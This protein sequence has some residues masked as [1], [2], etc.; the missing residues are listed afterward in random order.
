MLCVVG[1]VVRRDVS[2]HARGAMPRHGDKTA[3]QEASPDVIAM[4][5]G[6]EARVA[7]DDPPLED[8]LM[9][10]RSDRGLGRRGLGR[11]GDA[12]ALYRRALGTDPGNLEALM[13]FG[14]GLYRSPDESEPRQVKRCLDRA[15]AP[16][17]ALPEGRRAGRNALAR[18]AAT[19]PIRQTPNGAPPP[20][21]TG[22][23]R[24]PARETKTEGS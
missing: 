6:L 5:A 21:R 18:I 12:V 4:A 14:S 16:E 15:L 1:D 9:L 11:R 8:L 23:V 10:A 24:K 22:R 17:P 7:E 13:S 19:D 20:G 3:G 2:P